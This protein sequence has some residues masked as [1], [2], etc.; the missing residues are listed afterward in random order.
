MSESLA[1]QNESENSALTVLLVED[2][3]LLRIHAAE[4]LRAAGFIVIEAVNGREAVSV[5]QSRLHVDLVLTDGRM[6]LLDGNEL[7]RHI[8]REAPYLKIFMCAGQLPP[9]DVY[10]MLDGFFFEATRFR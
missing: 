3:S 4:R 2:E 7:V 10:R 8:R 6:P 1:L 9:E 5:L